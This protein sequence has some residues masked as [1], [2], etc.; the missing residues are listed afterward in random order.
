MWKMM[1][2]QSAMSN[3]HYAHK[4][5]GIHGH[6]QRG[7][8]VNTR[9]LYPDPKLDPVAGKH[10]ALNKKKSYFPNRYGEQRW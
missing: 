5:L 6:E 1:T 10:V 7:H 9:S 2:V 4:G 3:T 8:P